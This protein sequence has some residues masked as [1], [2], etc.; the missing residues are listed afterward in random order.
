MYTDLQ[1]HMCAVCLRC[2][3]SMLLIPL[4]SSLIMLH[5]LHVIYTDPYVT[6]GSKTQINITII[7]TNIV[8][9]A[10]TN[11]RLLHVLHR[12]WPLILHLKW[13][14]KPNVVNRRRRPVRVWQKPTKSRRHERPP[15]FVLMTILWLNESTQWENKQWEPRATNATLC[16][17]FFLF[18]FWWY[19]SVHWNALAGFCQ[20]SIVS[21][22]QLSGNT[23]RQRCR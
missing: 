4:F 20:I 5:F 16:Q 14:G 6:L 11:T 9:S 18:C 2:F 12:V 19:S 1:S 7:K 22:M 3:Q 15:A 10:K 17:G 8:V 21:T 23:N 13:L